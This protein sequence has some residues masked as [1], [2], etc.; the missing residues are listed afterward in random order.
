MTNLNIL[1]RLSH[2]EGVKELTSLRAP[3][4]QQWGNNKGQEC[5]HDSAILIQTVVNNTCG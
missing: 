1:T 3:E 5:D 2:E 4:Y